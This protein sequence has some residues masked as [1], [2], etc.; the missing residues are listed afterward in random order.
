[1]A[2]SLFVAAGCGASA[3]VGQVASS[4]PSTTAGRKTAPAG[5]SARRPRPASTRALDEFVEHDKKQD[6]NEDVCKSVAELVPDAS[7]EQQSAAGKPLP[8]AIYNA[9]LAYQRC[10]KDAEARSQFEAAV[11]AD[12]TIHRAK[13][14]LAL[15]DFQ[16]GERHRRARFSSSTR[17]S[18][19][20]SSRTSR[21][22]WRSP[23]CRWSAA[24]ISPTGRQERPRARA[25]QPAA[26]ARHRR[27]L[28]AGVQPARDLLPRAS[29]RQGRAGER[30]HQGQARSPQAGRVELEARRRQRAAA[31]SRGARGSQA[32]QKNP[33]YAPIHNTTGLIQ[34]ELKN[35][36]GAVKSFGRA[37]QLDPKFF[38]AHMN[39]A[40]VNLSFRGFEEAEK[41]YREALRLRPNE[42]EA[43][44]GLALALR[45]Q[46]NDGN[47][48][49][50][51]AEAREGARRRQ[52]DR[53]PA[54]GD[55]LQRGDPHAGVQGQ[56]RSTRCRRS[57]R[58][59]GSTTTSSPRPAA[60]PRS[61]TP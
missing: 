38:E 47:F 5:P 60:T 14:Q 42:Y 11:R 33:N 61:P 21:R 39:Y 36:N 19:T 50:N 30:A 16:K 6:W 24:A 43:H 1:M 22:S 55:L 35:F 7:K 17:S 18:A 28:H 37:R 48:D 49:K 2:A 57:R 34:V 40:A 20:R 41:A 3:V 46:I 51:V 9:G 10:G 44:L 12:G 4:I 13:A 25:A 29:A 31:R 45:G 8:E 15:Y 23:R 27:Q 56:A 32:Q 59:P 58:R 53:R 52:E 26:R 54:P